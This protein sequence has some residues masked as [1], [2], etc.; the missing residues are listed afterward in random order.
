MSINRRSIVVSGIIILIGVAVGLWFV[1]LISGFRLNQRQILFEVEHINAW[2]GNTTG[3]FIDG[4]GIV[5]TFSNN[6]PENV[7]VSF[8]TW[9]KG[10]PP[11]TTRDLFKYYGNSSQLAG[12]IDAK[13]ITAMTALIQPASSGIL[14]DDDP[15]T[16]FT[17]ASHDAGIYSYRA[18]LYDRK[19]KTHTPV[20][21]YTMGDITEVNLSQAG[22]TLHTWL[23]TI[24]IEDDYVDGCKPSRRI[25]RP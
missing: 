1:S 3:F 17:C 15:L 6:P 5:Y 19:R 20:D 12:K 18:Y 23:E 14:S 22:R 21:L 11:Y 25:C 16:P 7:F 8:F 2:T 10:E 4:D 24:C 13:V 9:G